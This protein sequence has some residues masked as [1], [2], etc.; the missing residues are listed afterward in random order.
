VQ[1]PSPRPQ[2]LVVRSHV[3]RDLLQSAALFKTEKLVVWEYIANGLQYCR[4]GV[5]PQVDVTVDPANRRIRVQDNGRG[6]DREG[7]RNFFVMHGENL[8]RKAGRRGR[9]RFGTGKSAAFGI[10]H[11][12]RVSSVCDGRRNAVE[13]TRHHIETAGDAPIPLT[14]I[15]SDQ[16]TSEEPGTLIEIAEIRLRIL[17]HAGIVRFIE[18]HLARW[19]GKPVVTVNGRQCESYEPPVARSETLHPPAPLA[20][21]LGECRLVLKVAKVPLD[22]E[23]CGVSIFA[24]GVWLDSTLAGAEGQPMSQF[25]LGEID[26]PALDDDTAD[27]PA[28]DMSRSMQLNP[29]NPVVA[30]L[31]Q[32]LGP[33]IDKLRHSLVSEDRRR[34]A[35]RDARHLAREADLIARMINDDFRDFSERVTR[36]RSRPGTAHDAG[37]QPSGAGDDPLLLVSGGTVPAEPLAVTGARPSVGSDAS[38]PEGAPRA[39]SDCKPDANGNLLGRPSGGEGSR[40][41]PRGGFS[42]DFRSMT[43]AEKRAKYVRGERTIYVNLDHPQIAAAKGAGATD[44]PLFRRLAYEVAFSEYAIAL[45]SELAENDQYIE[46]SDP[47]FDIRDTLDRMARRAASLYATD[48]Q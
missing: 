44:D 28:F 20:E 16:P 38:D 26:V 14:V 34:K 29:N 23:L 46:P 9:G 1:K 4:P 10:A 24:N 47:V 42:V 13:L 45:A 5:C 31:F 22:R 15:E 30:A 37:P 27:I 36:T 2:P 40:P 32:F 12:L 11:T 25:I 48:N 3:A 19:P 35:E 21:V 17:D 18:R 6:M 39:A 7:L 33:A 8:D 41:R 43:E